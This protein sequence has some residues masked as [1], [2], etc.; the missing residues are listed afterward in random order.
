[1]T[2][3]DVGLWCKLVFI[4]ITTITLLY[5]EYEIERACIVIIIIANTSKLFYYHSLLVVV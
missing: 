2:I 5:S 3:S 4:I 1:M